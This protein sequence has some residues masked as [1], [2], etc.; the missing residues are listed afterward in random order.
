MKRLTTRALR[1][2]AVLLAAGLASCGIADAPEHPAPITNV[3][4]FYFPLSDVGVSFAYCRAT[5]IGTDTVR[6]TMN[7]RDQTTVGQSPDRRCYAVGISNRDQFHSDLYFVVNDSE[8]ATVGS[9]SCGSGGATWLDLKS[10][11][12]EG[13]QWQFNTGNFYSPEL[14]TATVTRRGAQMKMPAGQV[15]DDVTEVQYVTAESDTTVKWFA[16]GVGLI[17]SSST[18]PDAYFGSE[19]KYIGP[20]Q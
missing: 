19:M 2:P 7:G 13:Q 17:Y 1:V 16:R 14:V 10:P 15:F 9:V 4:Q 6:M 5:S 8:A 11:L 3:S 18:R 12:T 20:V